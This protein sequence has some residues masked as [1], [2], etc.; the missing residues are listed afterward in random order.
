M[1]I[2]NRRAEELEMEMETQIRCV[3]MTFKGHAAFGSGTFRLAKSLLWN[4]NQG[5]HSLA[6]EF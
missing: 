5:L 2:F 3:A 6:R 4:I 1:Y